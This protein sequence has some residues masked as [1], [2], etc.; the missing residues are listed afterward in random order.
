MFIQHTLHGTMPADSCHSTIVPIR[1]PESDS[2]L[3]ID[4]VQ[5]HL[6]QPKTH[7]E[8]VDELEAEFWKQTEKGADIVDRLT[9]GEA[10]FTAIAAKYHGAWEYLKSDAH[11]AEFH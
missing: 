3:Y 11:C 6:A 1:Y 7:L 5:F 8:L 10:A 9:A 2:L 4:I